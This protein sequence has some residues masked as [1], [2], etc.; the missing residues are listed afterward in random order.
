M[1]ASQLSVQLEGDRPGPKTRSQEI[2]ATQLV[3][4]SYK[5]DLGRLK[6]RFT[7]DS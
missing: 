2:V 7:L 5:S 4:A 3:G 6:V 1:R